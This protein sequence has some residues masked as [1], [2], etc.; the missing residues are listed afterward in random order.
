MQQS[1]ED[2]LEEYC[3]EEALQTNLL[4]ILGSNAMCFI[5]FIER[6]CMALGVTI[7]S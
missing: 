7:F 5:L 3:L 1:N 6:I 4:L 2:K